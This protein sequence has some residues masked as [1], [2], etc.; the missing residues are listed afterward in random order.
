LAAG[1]I[2]VWVSVS[3]TDMAAALRVL[4]E[5]VDRIEFA[6]TPEWLPDSGNTSPKPLPLRLIPA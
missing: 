2:T 1:R 5:T 4:V 6:G 3:R